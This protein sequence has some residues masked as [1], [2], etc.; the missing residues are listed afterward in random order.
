MG[1]FWGSGWG[2][3]WG[4]LDWFGDFGV[5]TFGW[6]WVAGYGGVAFWDHVFFWFFEGGCVGYRGV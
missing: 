3:G 4:G 5:E 6:V 1:R 2:W